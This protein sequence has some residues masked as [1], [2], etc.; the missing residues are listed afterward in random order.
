VFYLFFVSSRYYLDDV[1]FNNLQDLEEQD[2]EQQLA[3]NLVKCPWP[4][5]TS[6]LS[7][8]PHLHELNWYYSL[9]YI[10]YGMRVQV[11]IA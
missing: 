4:Y 1:I 2:F 10:G 9:L 7:T 11:D 3:R 6:F 8:Y 5:R